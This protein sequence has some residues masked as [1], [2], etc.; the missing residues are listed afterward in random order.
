MRRENTERVTR[1]DMARPDLSDESNALALPEPPDGYV[2]RWVR[3]SI[4]GEE[5]YKNVNQRFDREGWE[6]VKLAEVPA[7]YRISSRKGGRFDGCVQ[8]GD[9]ILAKLPAERNEEFKKRIRERTLQQTEGIKNQLMRASDSKMPIFDDS[10]ANITFG[11]RRTAI[12]D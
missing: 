6:P 4:R 9:V 12:D 8:N 11:R 7:A 2:Y 3:V 1:E 10:R 5:D